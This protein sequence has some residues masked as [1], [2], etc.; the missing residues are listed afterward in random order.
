MPEDVKGQSEIDQVSIKHCGLYGSWLC[1][2]LSWTGSGC[3]IACQPVSY[4]ASQFGNESVT[5]AQKEGI[6]IKC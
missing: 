2:S 5:P 4:E 1:E 6:V 3:L